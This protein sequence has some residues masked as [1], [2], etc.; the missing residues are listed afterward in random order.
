MKLPWRAIVTIRVLLTKTFLALS[1]KSFG[2]ENC[3]SRPPSKFGSQ[4][5][6][7]RGEE[8]KRVSRQPTSK[9]PKAGRNG[10]TQN[11]QTP[12]NPYRSRMST[13]TF[14]RNSKTAPQKGQG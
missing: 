2:K 1:L 12:T 3:N 8:P 11:I 4:G 10:E 5:K 6:P 14:N 13:G 7:I 9:T